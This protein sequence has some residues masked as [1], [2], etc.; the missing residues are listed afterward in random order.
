MTPSSARRRR[1]H[2]DPITCELLH[3]LQSSAENDTP[4][5]TVALV[6]GA[7]KTGHPRTNITGLGNDLELVLIVGDDF[8]KFILDVVRFDR[9]ATNICQ[10]FGSSLE[11]AFHDVITRRFG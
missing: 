2:H 7:M 8:G 6:E 3:H 4:E 10:G 11:L 5:I 1:W 9:L